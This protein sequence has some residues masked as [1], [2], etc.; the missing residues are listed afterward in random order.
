[1]VGLNPLKGFKPKTH[2]GISLRAYETKGRKEKTQP[3]NIRKSKRSLVIRTG[4]GYLG[5]ARSS[6]SSGHATK[7]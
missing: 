2:E 1:M 5:I 7:L 6:R 3:A 4:L